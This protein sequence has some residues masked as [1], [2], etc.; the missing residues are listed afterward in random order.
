M[1]TVTS[2]ARRVRGQGGFALTLVLALIVVG[3][4]VTTAVLAFAATS[5][6]AGSVY[7]SRDAARARERDALDYLVE[8]IRPNLTKG[9]AGNTQTATVA[10]ATATCVGQTGS[11]TL[12]TPPAQGRADRVITCSTTSITA[13][14]R[15]FDRSGD[16]PGII[17]ETLAYDVS[18]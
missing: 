13:K 4:T 5:V 15:I 10:G 8:S 16:Q 1:G 11:G 2:S 12:A 7:S 17:V 18:D 3:V 6:Q 9:I 14:Y